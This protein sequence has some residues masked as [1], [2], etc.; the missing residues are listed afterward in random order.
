MR[1]AHVALAE[2]TE[3]IELY[4]DTAGHTFAVSIGGL[5]P[6]SAREIARERRM[7]LHGH[8]F[9]ESIPAGWRKGPAEPLGGWREEEE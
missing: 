9:L 1:E 2:A 3:G 8:R 6:E 4:H 7:C 5:T